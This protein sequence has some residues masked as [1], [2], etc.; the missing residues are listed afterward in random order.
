MVRSYT[1]YGRMKILGTKEQWP[2]FINENSWRTQFLALH[3]H[4]LGALPSTKP[5]VR[6][7]MLVSRARHHPL[8]HVVLVTQWFSSK[9]STCNAGDMGSIPGLGRFPGEGNGNSLQHSCLRNP[10]DRGAWRATVHG[11]AKSQTQLRTEYQIFNDMIL[12]RHIK[13]FVSYINTLKKKPLCHK[14]HKHQSH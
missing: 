6:T 7:V 10:M 2:K 9:E 14:T 13:D 1:Y 12:T 3:C 5:C 4:L 11:V 8:T